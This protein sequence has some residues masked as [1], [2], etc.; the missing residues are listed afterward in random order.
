M[1][2]LNAEPKAIRYYQMRFTFQYASIKRFT[3]NLLWIV[4][5]IFTFQYASIKRNLVETI[6]ETFENLHFNMLLLNRQAE[7]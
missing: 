4:A 5:L 6:S 3:H 1:L 2:L 7:G